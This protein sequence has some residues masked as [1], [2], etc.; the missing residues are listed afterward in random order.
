MSAALAKVYI[1]P[2]EEPDRDDGTMSFLEHLE[3]LRTRLIRVCLAIGAGMIV[4]FTFV[5]RLADFVLAPARRAIA[6]AVSPRPAGH[7]QPSPRPPA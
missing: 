4:A 6:W 7:R 5:M 3:E 2:P 1:P